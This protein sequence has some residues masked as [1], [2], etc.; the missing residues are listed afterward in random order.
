MGLAGLL[1]KELRCLARRELKPT[2]TRL[3]RTQRQLA[4]LRQIVRKQK[5][6]L[7]AFQ[8]QRAGRRRAARTLTL[9][10]ERRAIL[11]LQAGTWAIS[12]T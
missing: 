11:K 7:D 4:R 1:Q 5:R 10:P 12:A 2:T 3:N 8:R 6:T 9:S